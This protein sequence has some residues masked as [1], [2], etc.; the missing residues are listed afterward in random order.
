MLMAMAPV[1]SQY[2]RRWAGRLHDEAGGNTVEYVLTV[3][4]V[5]T[6]VVTVVYVVHKL[7]P[8]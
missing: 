5:L 4:V 6:L 3:G 7:L 2:A 8:A 1:L